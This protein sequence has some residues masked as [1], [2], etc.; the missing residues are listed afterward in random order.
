MKRDVREYTRGMGYALPRPVRRWLEGKVFG[1]RE[2][3]KLAIIRL[4]NLVGR[5]H[6]EL[7][8]EPDGWKIT[9]LVL[10]VL[11]GEVKVDAAGYLDLVGGRG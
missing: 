6:T 2:P 9:R 11:W 3:L 10:E 4:A 5:Y 1:L 7:R 8:R